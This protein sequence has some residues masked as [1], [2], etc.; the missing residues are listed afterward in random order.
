MPQVL[1]DWAAIAVC[2]QFCGEAGEPV[3]VRPRLRLRRH[4]QTRGAAMEN[5]CLCVEA[6]PVSLAKISVH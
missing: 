6:G 4:S 3:C 1:G 2:R 5:G